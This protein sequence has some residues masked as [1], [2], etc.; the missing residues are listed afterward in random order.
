MRTDYFRIAYG[1]SRF[2]LRLM[3]KQNRV[4]RST[5]FTGGPAELYP[6]VRAPGHS[7]ASL[8]LSHLRVRRVLARSFLVALAYRQFESLS[9]RQPQRSQLFSRWTW[10]AIEPKRNSDF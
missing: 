7:S 8:I 4:R 10:L 9:L 5:D 6:V 1:V 2:E 3:A